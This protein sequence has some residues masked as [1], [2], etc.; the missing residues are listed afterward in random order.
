MTLPR[1]QQE[2][3]QLEYYKNDKFAFLSCKV[4]EFVEGLDKT[5]LA[6]LVQSK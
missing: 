2:D 3:G 6:S 1:I 5:L 4:N